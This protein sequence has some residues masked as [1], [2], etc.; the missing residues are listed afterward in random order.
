[1][2]FEKIAVYSQI[3]VQS[4]GLAPVKL[5]EPQGNGGGLWD[6]PV[7]PWTVCW[8]CCKRGGKFAHHELTSL[9]FFL[10]SNLVSQYCTVPRRLTSSLQ[11]HT[12]ISVT[13][14]LYD[15]CP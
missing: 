8:G 1:M 4:P 6:S 2:S 9:C 15:I 14:S 5:Q 3:P 7:D 11:P 12:R 13:W 10:G